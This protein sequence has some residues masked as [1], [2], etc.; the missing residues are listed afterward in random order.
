MPRGIKPTQYGKI[1]LTSEEL[2]QPVDV[3]I[4]SD[5]K[6]F[7][8][9]IYETTE[10]CSD[11]TYVRVC[12]IKEHQQEENVE[13]TLTVQEDV[14]HILQEQ[15]EFVVM[16]QELFTAT[17]EF[18]KETLLLKDHLLLLLT[19]LERKVLLVNLTQQK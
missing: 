9:P 1:K 17:E 6:D 3:E 19:F 18:H 11:T 5:R 13:T 16:N 2:K 4:V 12:R 15:E 10:R 8:G 7:K 14:E